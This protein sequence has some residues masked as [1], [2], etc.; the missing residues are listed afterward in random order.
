MRKV[1]NIEKNKKGFTII[2]LLVVMS[3]ICVLCGIAIPLFA[4]S[5]MKAGDTAAKV[6][7]RNVMEFLDIYYLNYDTYPE[8][9]DDLLA[10]GC[11]LSRNVS[12]T[13]YS[14]SDFGDD[15]VTVHMHIK[16][17]SSSNAWHANHPKEGT[18]V[19]IR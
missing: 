13:N 17:V 12:F 4:S 7:L 11:R 1:L 8:T 18:E 6:D 5:R 16:H 2:E 19:E 9:V 14:I 15:Q 10:A 3:I